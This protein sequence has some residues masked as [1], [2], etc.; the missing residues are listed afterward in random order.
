MNTY[1]AEELKKIAK[2]QSL[3]CWFLLFSIL[4]NIFVFFIRIVG[5]VDPGTQPLE[6]VLMAI[7]TYCQLF[8]RIAVLIA[9]V[10]WY[11]K[12]AKSL[13]GKAPFLVIPLLFLPLINLLV[14]AHLVGKAT[15][16]LRAH[17]IRVG[18]MG[19]RKEDLQNL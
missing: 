4:L 11:Y 3:V 10:V 17:N 7:I 5:E 15:R 2:Y 19:A 13:K 14:V 16:V 6:A 9:M 1:S 8:T 12:L 18:L